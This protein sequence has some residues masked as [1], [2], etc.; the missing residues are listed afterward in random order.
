[1]HHSNESSLS[2]YCNRIVLV[3]HFWEYLPAV[4][5]HG[6]LISGQHLTGLQS[7]QT[8]NP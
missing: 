1:M 6:I 5:N 7:R 4:Q 3:L 8:N 2:I